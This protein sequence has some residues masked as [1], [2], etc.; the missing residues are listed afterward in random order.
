MI[1]QFISYPF[2]RATSK[3]LFHYAV[4]QLVQQRL[5]DEKGLQTLK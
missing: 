1:L 5:E 4:Q 2:E 3:E